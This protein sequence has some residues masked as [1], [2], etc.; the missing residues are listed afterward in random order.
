MKRSTPSKYVGICLLALSSVFSLSSQA[1][2]IKSSDTTQNVKPLPIK[3]GSNFSLSPRFMTGKE[4][5]QTT[6][7]LKNNCFPFQ[8]VSSNSYMNVT[9]DDGAVLSVP[10]FQRKG[11][12]QKTYTVYTHVTVYNPYAGK[13]IYDGKIYD[14]VGLFCDAD[15]CTPWN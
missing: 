11:F 4:F 12:S 6:L 14:M 10:M 1:I 15:H 13:T 9:F 2:A 7:G 5:C 8:N 3:S